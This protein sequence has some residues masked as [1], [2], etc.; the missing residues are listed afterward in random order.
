[1]ARAE[2]RVDRVVIRMYRLGTGDCFTIKFMKGS[3]VSY[4][5]MIDCGC[6]NIEKPRL[7][8]F[9]KELKKDMANRVDALVVTH[10]HKD[11]VFGFEQAEDMFTDGKFRAEQT[12]MAWTEEDG[13]DDIEQWKQDHGDKKKSLAF[14]ARKLS[15]AVKDPAFQEQ[16]GAARDPKVLHKRRGEFSEVLSGFADLHGAVPEVADFAAAKAYVG[17]LAGMKIVKEKLASGAIKYRRPGD[18]IENQPGLDGVRIFVLGP[19]TLYEDVKREKG[20]KG[21]A[22]EHNKD[23]DELEDTEAFAAALTTFDG[24]DSARSLPF[25]KGYVADDAAARALYDKEAWRKI[26]YDWLLSAGSLALRMSSRTNNLSLVLAIEFVDSG[27]VLLFPGDAEFGS[28]SSWH[29]ID[30]DRKVK[31]LTTEKLLN[32]VVF[33]KVAHHL[34]HNGTARSIGLDMMTS[35]DLVAM[36]TLDYESI[37]PGWTSTMPN[38]GIIKDLL[39]KTKGRTIIM[40][41][42]DLFFDRQKTV[43]LEDKIE[44]YRKRMSKDER[45]AFEESL[46]ETDHYIS[47]T[48]DV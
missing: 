46:E 37:S 5:M 23:L 11:H 31:D 27:K 7:V 25:D 29:Q 48:L 24:P 22:Y 26:D 45:D 19:P 6:W 18:V 21:E 16:V 3:K 28:W 4:K 13:A 47:L 1:M 42:K 10:E 40:K 41:R 32:R 33:Y 44:E 8:P 12:W 30:W 39:E 36:A 34:S 14:A 43:K 2:K 9:I 17:G 35:P 38:V 20:P 15:E